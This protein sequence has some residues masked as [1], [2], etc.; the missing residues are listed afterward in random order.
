MGFQQANR[1]F[2]CKN[3]FYVVNKAV[4]GFLKGSSTDY[5]QEINATDLCALIMIDN[6]SY[7]RY[8]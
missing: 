2:E 3:T 4:N 5:H 1:I 8:T 6:A 7:H